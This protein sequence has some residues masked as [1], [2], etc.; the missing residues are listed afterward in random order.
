MELPFK[1]SFEVKKLL[2]IHSN[3]PQCDPAPKKEAILNLLKIIYLIKKSQISPRLFYGTVSQIEKW[4]P[5]SFRG[6]KEPYHYNM[7]KTRDSSTDAL[8]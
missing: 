4:P 5:L 2:L 7:L 3:S 1:Q 6:S 8:E